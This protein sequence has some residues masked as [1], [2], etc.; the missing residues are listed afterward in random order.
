MRVNLLPAQYHGKSFS[1]K[2]ILSLI[3]PILAIVFLVVF[4]FF[5]SHQISV[6][7]NDVKSLESEHQVLERTLLQVRG[8]E[9]DL[10]TMQDYLLSAQQFQKDIDWSDLLMELGYLVQDEI[11]LTSFVIT[12]DNKVTFIGYVKNFGLITTL[13][14]RIDSSPYF[15]STTLLTTGLS[16]REEEMEFRIESQ[17][18]RGNYP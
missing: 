5:S 8:V 2:R 10:M 11:Q 12:F 4:Y 18:V 7:K 16:R 1:P 14:N 15:T 9:R 17:L 13:T 3:I 6:L